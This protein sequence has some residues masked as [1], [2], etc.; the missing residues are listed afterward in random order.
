[1]QITC[2]AVSEKPF[3]HTHTHEERHR[4][5]MSSGDNNAAVFIL[6]PS[7][8]AA[9]RP[10]SPTMSDSPLSEAPASR[11]HSPASTSPKISQTEIDPITALED[12]EKPLQKRKREDNDDGEGRS[13]GWHPRYAKDPGPEVTLES[14]DGCLF[15][16]RRSL[17]ASHR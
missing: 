15:T 3:T 14:D 10:H 12:Q 9:R 6:K 4:E 11:F 5:S 13:N 16:V 7:C 8:I 1:M 17:L 2:H